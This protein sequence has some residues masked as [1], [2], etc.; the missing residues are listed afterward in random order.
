M[1]DGKKAFGDFIGSVQFERHA[2]ETEIND[3]RALIAA[4]ANKGVGIRAAH[5]DPLRFTLDG[6]GRRLRG[7]KTGGYGWSGGGETAFGPFGFDGNGRRWRRLR[8]C[9]AGSA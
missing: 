5:G 2:A 3:A 8:F 4:F 1:E 7:R 6:E 9:I